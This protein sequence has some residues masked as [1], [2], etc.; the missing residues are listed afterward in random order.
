MCLRNALYLC[1][2]TKLRNTP[3]ENVMK[4][5]LI[6]LILLPFMVAVS[7]FQANAKPSTK[8]VTVGIVAPVA[9]PAMTEIINGFKQELKSLYHG[10]IHFI[11]ANAQGDINIQ[12]SILQQFKAKQVDLVVPV[13]TATAQMANALN[14][15][16]PIV[17]LAAEFTSAKRA[18]FRNKNI[19]NILD[20]VDVGKQLKFIHTAFPK[21]KKMTLIYSPNDHIFPQVKEAKKLAKQYGIAIQALMIQG[22]PQLYTVSKQIAPDSQ[23][24]FIL[25][26]ELVVSGINTL[27]KQAAQRKLLLIA[28]D[29][30]SV[31]SGADFAVGVSERL[32]GVGGAKLAAEVLNGKPV[33]DIPVKVMTRYHV[34]VSPAYENS[35]MFGP[36]F[37]F[38]NIKS[39][40]KQFGYPVETLASVQN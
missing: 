4:K 7:A 30:G 23:A 11:V 28:S 13:G 35:K 5:N 34:Y 25:K 1:T 16:Q 19:T 37:S 31:K 40:A 20:E 29:D 2:I 24:I 14:T 12:R 38:A 10:Q 6:L 36:D 17:A 21:L 8:P 22:L 18:H 27:V 3:Q 15:S 9:I 26:D 32:I 33:A 39:S